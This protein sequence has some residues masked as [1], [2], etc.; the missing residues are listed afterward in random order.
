MKRRQN[1]RAKTPPI[2]KV[3]KKCECY[4]LKDDKTAEYWG[5]KE[6][7]ICF[8]SGDAKFCNFY[9]NRDKIGG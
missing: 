7:K 6:R 1:L 3:V 4:P 2:T 9:H 8:C 5:T